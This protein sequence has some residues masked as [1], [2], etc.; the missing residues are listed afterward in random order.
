MT[1]GVGIYYKS[2]M[3]FEIERSKVKV[4]ESMTLHNDISFQTTTALHSHSLGGDTVLTRAILRGF[5]LYEYILVSKSVR[6]ELN[7]NTATVNS[8]L[9][10]HC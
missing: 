2:D 9:T 8:V 3:V 7:R 4:T 1:L 5:E 10:K 6:R